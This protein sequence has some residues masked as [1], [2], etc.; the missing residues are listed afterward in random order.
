VDALTNGVATVRENIGPYLRLALSY[1]IASTLGVLSL[2]GFLLG[3][4]AVP[5]WLLSVLTDQR[6]AVRA[7]D[8]ALPNWLRDDFWA[9]IRI[10]DRSFG[11][12]LRGILL[13]AFLVG[14]GMLTGLLLL[15]RYGVAD[16]PYP[17][18]LALFAGLRR[19]PRC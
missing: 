9:V 11:V 2:I 16:I 8:R 15:G 4:L 12:Y 5:T 1:G 19:S 6:T 18:V 7:L 17:L 14:C 13:Q 10:F 3:F